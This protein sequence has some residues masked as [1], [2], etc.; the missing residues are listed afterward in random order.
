MTLPVGRRSRLLRRRGGV[1]FDLF[2][3]SFSTN[4]RHKFTSERI[5][6]DFILLL[7]TQHW[8]ETSKT[9]Q[10][11]T[12]SQ[13]SQSA[14]A[15]RYSKWFLSKANKLWSEYKATVSNKSYVGLETS[16]LRINTWYR[17]TLPLYCGVDSCNSLSVCTAITSTNKSCF[18]FPSGYRVRPSH[19]LLRCVVEDPVFLVL[20]V[21]FRHIHGRIVYSWQVSKVKR[22]SSLP[23]KCWPFLY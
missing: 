3:L 14:A 4:R 2:A 18:T 19:R 16:D 12:I 15:K 17:N 10:N 9:S 8:T 20:T 6:P 5:L 21:C 13:K 11:F 1:V 7:C 22:Q 23:R